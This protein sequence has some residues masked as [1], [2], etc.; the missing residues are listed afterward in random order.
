MPRA[1]KL[2]QNEGAP[3]PGVGSPVASAAAASGGPSSPGRRP[4]SRQPTRTPTGGTYGSGVAAE[5]AQRAAPLPQAQPP[6]AAGGQPVM[7]P[8]PR[9]RFAEALQA[10]KDMPFEDVPISARSE[11]PM[12]PVTAGLPIGPGPGPEVL[13]RTGA[14]SVSDTLQRLAD[15]TGDQEVAALAET[16]RSQKA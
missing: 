15:V 13:G 2:P 1:K 14:P 10:A 11:R 4:P 7:A 12:E 8:N 9:D 6:N 5:R 3:V 16:A